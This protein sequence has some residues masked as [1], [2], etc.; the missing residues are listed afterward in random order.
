MFTGGFTV[1]AAEA[2]MADFASSSDASADADFLGINVLTG[3]ESLID[4]SLLRRDD[5][6]AAD[7]RITMY[8][9]I[10]EYGTKQLVRL[11]IGR[12]QTGRRPITDESRGR[13]RRPGGLGRGHG[14]LQG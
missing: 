7:L 8:E 10:R 1:E 14:P 11:A 9:T 3:V 4:K 13:C 6:N 5:Q 2:I 12:K